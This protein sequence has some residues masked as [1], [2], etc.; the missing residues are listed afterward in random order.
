MKST[1]EPVV[2]GIGD[3]TF[4]VVAGWPQLPSHM[5]FFEVAA[6]STDSRD[7][8]YVFNRGSQPVVVMSPSGKFLG[9]WGRGVFSRPHGITI[10]NDAI[11]CVDD[12]DHTVK[13]FS[14][15]GEL[16]MKLG[17]SGRFSDTGATTLDYRKIRNAAGPFNFPTNLG[18]SPSG[19]LYIADGYG[20]S[21]IH[22]FSA[23]GN[24]LSSWGRPGSGPGEFHIPHGLAI[25]ADGLVYV[26]DRENS[27][28]QIFSPEG[29]YLREWKNV[30]RP[31]Q[32]FI[33][34]ASRVYV[35]ELGYRAGMWP[36]TSPPMPK[37]VGGRLS[38]F[39]LDGTLLS[40][41]GGGDNPC[42]AGDFFAP[43]DVWID[44]QG[45]VYVSEV[46]MSAGGNRGIVD[47]KC[48]TLQKF[49]PRR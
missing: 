6:V 7:R 3:L 35:A 49:E 1:S 23:T 36:G 27:R 30:A 25:D 19:D 34:A 12:L 46:V 20:N 22:R 15:D 41:W 44:S 40:R 26:A 32:C 10:H 47:P 28:I 17:E 8:V 29:E 11:Y 31:C 45:A 13:Q 16:L 37:A 21:R 5:D 33:D 2:V 4:R 48:H 14:L 39:A 9:S 42:A 18:V 43:H 24:L 38:V